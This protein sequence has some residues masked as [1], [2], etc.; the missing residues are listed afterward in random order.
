MNINQNVSR[1]SSITSKQSIPQPLQNRNLTDLSGPIRPKVANLFDES[2]SDSEEF[3]PNTT[4]QQKVKV[5]P[6][7]PKQ[8]KEQSSSIFRPQKAPIAKSTV[9]VSANLFNDEPPEFDVPIKNDRKPTSL[10]LESDD[11]NDNKSKVNTTVHPRTANPVIAPI[12]K[13]VNLF[14]DLSDDEPPIKPKETIQK[15]AAITRSNISNLFDDVPPDDLFDSIITKKPSKIK[16]NIFD[17][18]EDDFTIKSRT[19]VPQSTTKSRKIPK[20]ISTIAPSTNQFL[21]NLFDDA[22]DDDLDD[23]FSKPK[24]VLKPKT[25]ASKLFVSV[26]EDDF[27]EELKIPDDKLIEPASKLFE[28]ERKSIGKV[29]DTQ[30][31]MPKKQISKLFESDSEDDFDKLLKTTSVKAKEP[32]KIFEKDTEDDFDKVLTIPAKKR[33]ESAS[34]LFESEPEDDFDKLLKINNNKSKEQASKLFE[35]DAE[36]EN[37][38]NK[39]I[40]TVVSSVSDSTVLLQKKAE[41]ANSLGGHS[42]TSST[43]SRKEPEFANF[44]ARET[45]ESKLVKNRR[46][47]VSFLDNDPPSQDDDWDEIAS[48]SSSNF[49]EPKQQQN[50]DTTKTNIIED[51]RPVQIPDIPNKISPTTSESNAK[52]KVSDIFDDDAF[53]NEP[54]FIHDTPSDTIASVSSVN[55]YLS[56]SNSSDLLNVTRE[57]VESKFTLAATT[58]VSAMNVDLFD[59]QPPDDLFEKVV[60]KRQPSKPTLSSVGLFDDLPPDDDFP[61]ENVSNVGIFD[62]L[63]PDDDFPRGIS[64]RNCSFNQRARETTSVFYDDFADTVVKPPIDTQSLPNIFNDEPPPDVFPTKLKSIFDEDPPPEPR[65]DTFSEVESFGQVV[66]DM[67]VGVIR[68]TIENVSEDKRSSIDARLMPIEDKQKEIVRPFNESIDEPFLSNI[69]DQL[70]KVNTTSAAE[71]L[72]ISSDETDKADRFKEKL[73]KFASWEN[74]K[75]PVDVIE[76]PKPKKLTDNI[77]INVAALLPGAKL[78]SFKAS[79]VVSSD[80]FSS[81]EITRTE[82]AIDVLASQPITTTPT[83]QETIGRLNSLNKNRARITVQRRPSTRRGRQE[84]YRKSLATSS[85]EP[86]DTTA[87]LDIFKPTD[88]TNIRVETSYLNATIIKTKNSNVTEVEKNII[89][90]SIEDMFKNAEESDCVLAEEK[91][92]ALPQPMRQPTKKSEFK[93]TNVLST[94]NTIKNTSNSSKR[95]VDGREDKFSEKIIS[96]SSLFD[97]DDDHDDDNDWL[98]KSMKTTEKVKTET[99]TTQVT[100]TAEK[101]PSLFSEDDDDGDLFAPVSKRKSVP[102]KTQVPLSNASHFISS[103]GSNEKSQNE[104]RGSKPS[105]SIFGDDDDDDNDLFANRSASRRTSKP[106]LFANSSRPNNGPLFGDSDEDDGDIFATAKSKGK[107]LFYALD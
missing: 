57:N 13:T 84:E 51:K 103:R 39:N 105:K 28:S 42:V 36:D 104:I 19:S 54:E 102:Q 87:K 7:I 25:Q 59:N 47:F 12:K 75:P 88:V 32:S 74:E 93:S 85:E 18:I 79:L 78:P 15:P 95:S 66:N 82:K 83:E 67:Q 46:P 5:L 49:N 16:T 29:F 24:T 90:T 91:P 1:K 72:S 33:K 48:N 100:K 101:P 9:V 50:M 6:T 61:H 69:H 37:K 21:E 43:S 20:E 68:T 98:V 40:V 4:V 52:T 58:S 23:I 94:E 60:E 53:V 97:A 99:I 3:L 22:P 45:A 71:P 8:I 31:E 92:P 44:F 17:D 34:K 86:A 27:N 106:K 26:P 2:E 62:D 56:S 64:T 81:T 76:K 73:T 80:E 70:T 14:D 38:L 96:K 41:D 63:P 89:A 107:I 11:E 30:T 10:F 55:K 65:V 35:S 77:K